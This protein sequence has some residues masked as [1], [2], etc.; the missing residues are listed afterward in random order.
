M[1]AHERGGAEQA[2][3]FAVGEERDDVVRE[4]RTRAQRAQRLEQR[5][6]SGAIVAAAGPAGTPS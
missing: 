1:L 5:G 3:L 6:D 4:R 2:R